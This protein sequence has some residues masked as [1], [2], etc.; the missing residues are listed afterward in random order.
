MSSK[1]LARV[2]DALVPHNPRLRR[3]ASRL[4]NRRPDT[5]IGEIRAYFPSVLEQRLYM[6]LGKDFAIH[7]KTLATLLRMFL[8][9]HHLDVPDLDPIDLG[10]HLIASRLLDLSDY[11]RDCLWL[12]KQSGTS[13]ASRD[14]AALVLAYGD[15]AEMI[16]ETIEC[17]HALWAA[18]LGLREDAP[19]GV[20]LRRLIR[21][22]LPTFNRLGLPMPLTLDD[23]LAHRPLCARSH[24]HGHVRV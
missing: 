14:A 12:L 11:L 5:L 2:Q 23:L 4:H 9:H 16:V 20:C 24:A 19:L 3:I 21:D 13:F 1:A 8:D 6:H 7:P 10:H 22:V 17:D 15:A 18:A